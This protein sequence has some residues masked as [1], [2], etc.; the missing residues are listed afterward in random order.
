M[1]ASYE[2]L[3]QR[4]VEAARMAAA[5]HLHQSI[6]ER[7]PMFR[8]PVSIGGAGPEFVTDDER[9]TGAR[10]NTQRWRIARPDKD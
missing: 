1:D 10:N 2:K 8:Q 4:I 7:V 5:I 3:G 6:E 9:P